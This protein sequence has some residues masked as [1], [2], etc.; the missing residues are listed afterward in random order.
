MQVGIFE[1]ELDKKMIDIM[2]YLF[3]HFVIVVSY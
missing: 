3:Y 2:R 1:Y